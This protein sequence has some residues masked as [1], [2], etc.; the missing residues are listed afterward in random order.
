MAETSEIKRRRAAA[1]YRAL[2]KEYPGVRSALDFHTPFELLIATI[3]AAQSTDKN[4]NVV[5]K[6]LFSKYPN[7]QSYLDVPVEVLEKDIY[8]TGFYRAKANAIR[9]CCAKLL[10]DYH[11]EVPDAADDLLALPG[12]GRKTAN[13]VRGNAFGKNAIA[14]DTHVK[15]IAQLLKLA[16]TD[17]P[18]KIESQLQSVLAESAWTK[19][20]LLVAAHGR[21]V[22]IA[23]RPK[24]AECVI[25]QYCPSRND[26]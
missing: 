15:R 12:V 25:N 20:S 8:T 17:D 3:L 6:T 22:C 10:E 21:A 23:R 11:G 1:I 7:P 14:V 18:D 5:T 16:A 24:C 9:K 4:T 13:V 19:F 2:L 26:L